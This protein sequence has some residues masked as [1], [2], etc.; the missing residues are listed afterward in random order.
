MEESMYH[1]IREKT[2]NSIDIHNSIIK[3]INNLRKEKDREAS[4]L[5]NVGKIASL[6]SLYKEGLEMKMNLSEL[7]AYGEWVEGKVSSDD[8]KWD[9]IKEVIRN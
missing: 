8:F 4:Y 9:L 7:P 6:S 1:S 2:M 5:M 3:S